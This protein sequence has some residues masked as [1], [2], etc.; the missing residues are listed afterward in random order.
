VNL[1]AGDILDLDI[2]GEGGCQLIGTPAAQNGIHVMP[3]N[4][5]TIRGMRIFGFSKG[6]GIALS[7]ANSVQIVRNTINGNQHGIDMVTVPHYAPNAVHV[8]DNEIA[9]NDWGVYSRNGHAPATRA[10]GNVYR[11][12]VFEGNH[13]G[14]MFLGWD[15]HT[16]VEGNYFES[17]GVAITAGTGGDKVYDIHVVRNYFTVDGTFGYRSE[18]ELGD[19]SGFFVEGNYEE[20]RNGAGTGCAVNVVLGIRGGTSNVLLRNAFSRVS[21]GKMTT[22]EFC[23]EGKP[24]IPPGVLG[25]ERLIGD[26]SVD[27]TV[28]AKGAQLRGPLEFGEGSIA[29]TDAAIRANDTCT[30]EGMLLISRP[31]NQAAQLYFCTGFRWQPVI[32]PHH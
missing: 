10:L 9:A 2:D 17:T 29:S 18:V 4:M 25:E 8:A 15:A 26:L 27:G 6:N 24:E 16:L 21:E 28:R 31:S 23:Y 5:L 30:T 11:D 32:L 20:G 19:G 7:G 12:N 13:I 14:D 1:R 22:H 3:D